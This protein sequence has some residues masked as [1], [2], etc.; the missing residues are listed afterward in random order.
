MAFNLNKNDGSAESSNSKSKFDLS[1]NDVPLA[2]EDAHQQKSKALPYILIGLLIIAVGSWYFLSNKSSESA[3]GDEVANT[4][5]TDSITNASALKNDSAVP[6]ISIEASSGI[7]PVPAVSNKN[8]DA[9]AN[10]ASPFKN[11]IPVSFARGNTSLRNI[12]QSIVSDIVKYLT[13]NSAARLE[14]HGYASS[15]GSLEANQSIS[16]ARADAFKS[17]LVSRNVNEDRITAVGKGIA[18][19]IASNE[20]E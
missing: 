15:E 18:D 14:V 7:D 16:Q 1:K 2:Q 9:V 4:T 19:P 10:E 17:Y 11:K 3:S 13:S 5:Q 20:T 8:E 6:V 12:D